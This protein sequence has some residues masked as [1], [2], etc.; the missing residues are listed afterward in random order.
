MPQSPFH[1]PCRQK[2]LMRASLPLLSLLLL[3]AFAVYAGSAF[4]LQG[5]GDKAVQLVLVVPGVLLFALSGLDPFRGV[6]RFFKS[7]STGIFLLILLSGVFIFTV[8][9]AVVPLQGIPKGWGRGRLPFSKQDLRPGGA[10]R[11]GSRGG[12]SQGPFPLQALHLSR[13]RMVCDV[14]PS[15]EFSWLPL[16][17]Q[18]LP[19]SWGRYSRSFL[20]LGP[21][22]L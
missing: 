15:M 3:A 2:I 7:L 4:R 9:M 22:C 13:W 19:G 6:I 10:H 18:E 12:G 11:P 20:C 21:F 1:V 16:P 17:P 5:P 8:W 14:H